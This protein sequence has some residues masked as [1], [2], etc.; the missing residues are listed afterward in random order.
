MNP[1][2]K[3]NKFGRKGLIA[4]VLS[5]QFIGAT[6]A[7]ADNWISKSA[8]VNENIT[9]PYGLTDYTQAKLEKLIALAEKKNLK[10]KV[11]EGYRSQERQNKLYE[12]GRTTPG[13][14]V[15]WTRKSKHTTRLAFDIAAIKNGKV[16][17]NNADYEEIGALGKEAGLEW[18]GTW[19][20][21]KDRPHFQSAP[22]DVSLAKRSTELRNL[23]DHIAGATELN[24]INRKNVSDILF[25]TAIHESGGLQ[26]SERGKGIASSIFMIEP[27]T[28]EYMVKWSKKNPKAMNLLVAESGKTSEELLSMS[29][30][31]LS[32][33]IQEHDHFAAAMARVKY[34]SVPG[35]IPGTVEGRSKYWADNYMAGQKKD[36]KAKQYI[37][38]NIRV[39]KEVK[40]AGSIAT[41]P[42]K[43]VG[44]TNKVL[45]DSKTSSKMGTA[46]FKASK[47]LQK[48]IKR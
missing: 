19:K 17:W 13:E 12:Q 42:K 40:A 25:E 47:F 24:V 38:D 33:L 21:K 9:Q 39:A 11:T 35:A 22:M 5:S 31:Q 1:L 27:S 2:E 6:P 18:G 14:Q 37:D 32:K 41:A 44:L 8:S 29:K 26:W 23:T 28:A 16:S 43:T 45:Q 36:I 15:T 4:L 34:M 30:G 10:F 3:L 48:I 46:S 7:L 20:K